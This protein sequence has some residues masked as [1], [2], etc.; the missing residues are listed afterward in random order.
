MKTIA[1]PTK[2]TIADPTKE[3]IADPT[4][5]TIADPTEKAAAVLAVLE[6]ARLYPSRRAEES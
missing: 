3:T 6:S 1:D 5:K 4:K 2:K